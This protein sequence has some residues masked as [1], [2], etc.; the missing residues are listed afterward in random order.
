MGLC[1]RTTWRRTELIM[2]ARC[3][4]VWWLVP[5][6]AMQLGL[7]PTTFGTFIWCRALSNQ[8][9]NLLRW[10]SVLVWTKKLCFCGNL[11]ELWAS[12]SSWNHLSRPMA[13][14]AVMA[15]VCMRLDLWTNLEVTILQLFY[16]ELVY[17]MLD[18]CSSPDRVASHRFSWLFLG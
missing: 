10:A 5:L 17:S 1:T 3:Y 14:G 18:S 15:R 16:F 12:W 11:L 9:E 2:H 7:W 4:L 13:V 8:L 6:T